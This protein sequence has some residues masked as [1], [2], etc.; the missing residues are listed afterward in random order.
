M[1]PME[2]LENAMIFPVMT[3]K[4]HFLELESNFDVALDS[5]GIYFLFCFINREGLY[6]GE[7]LG[8]KQVMDLSRTADI[9]VTLKNAK[10]YLETT[11]FPNKEYRRLVEECKNKHESCAFWATLGECQNNPGY[12]NVSCAP[13]CQSCEYM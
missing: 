7:D 5:S 1:E 10:Q 11:I 13:V 9:Q 2:R 3:R 8:V 4:T 12:M 6:Y